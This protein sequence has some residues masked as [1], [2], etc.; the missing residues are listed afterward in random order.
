M[1]AQQAQGVEFDRVFLVGITPE[2]FTSEKNIPQELEKNLKKIR[3]DLL[4]VALTR[5]ID[6]LYIF[7]KVPLKTLTTSLL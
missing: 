1:T 7:G 6:E 5:A 2:I 3:K 4:Y